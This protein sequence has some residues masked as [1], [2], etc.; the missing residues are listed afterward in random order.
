MDTFSTGMH[1]H[2][3]VLEH[4]SFEVIFNPLPKSRFFFVVLQQS[5]PGLYASNFDKVGFL[6]LG[7]NFLPSKNHPLPIL[8]C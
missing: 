3:K 2:S 4:S 7:R 6:H 1:W 8:T 5:D